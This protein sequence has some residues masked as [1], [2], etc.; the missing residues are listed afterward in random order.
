MRFWCFSVVVVVVLVFCFVLFFKLVHVCRSH[1]GHLGLTAY[2]ED[3]PLKSIANF[4]HFISDISS[5]GQTLTF[6]PPVQYDHI[7]VVQTVDGV[8]LETK[9]EVGLLTRNVV[10]RGSVQ[11]EW[12]EEIEACAEEFDTS[13]A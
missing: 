6:E 4:V 11:E 7:S 1:Y 9:A 8:T 2:C 5:D 3:H 10:V 12:L 13:K